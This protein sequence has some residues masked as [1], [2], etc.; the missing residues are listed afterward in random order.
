MKHLLMNAKQEIED[1]RCRNNLL[2]A[3]VDVVEVFS[4]ALLGH[5]PQGGMSIDV[6]WELQRKID[7]MSENPPTAVPGAVIA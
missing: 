1:L 2:Q 7:E 4:A 3:K 6:V 5:R